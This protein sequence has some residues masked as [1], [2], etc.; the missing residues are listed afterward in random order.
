LRMR[1]SSMKFNAVMVQ[2][3]EPNIMN[4]MVS[5]VQATPPLK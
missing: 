2:R 5:I 4:T 3:T 1:R